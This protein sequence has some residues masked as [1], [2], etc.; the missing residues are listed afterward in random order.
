MARRREIAWGV[1]FTVAALTV[2]MASLADIGLRLMAAQIEQ[3]R[4]AISMTQLPTLFVIRETIVGII[5]GI[6]AF[7]MLD[8]STTA[9]QVTINRLN[10]WSL[11]LCVV[12]AL[13][14]RSFVPLY[15]IYISGFN[16]TLVVGVVLGVFWQ[17]RRYWR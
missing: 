5:V 4:D 14:V 16:L 3:L 1:L 10:L 6:S 15:G 2:F 17:S 13:G 9:T 7:S 11:I 12:V 8:R